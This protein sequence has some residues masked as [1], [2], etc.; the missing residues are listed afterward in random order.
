MITHELMSDKGVLVVCPTG[1]LE[2]CDFQE[3]AKTVDPF[4]AV[5]GGLRGLMIC[6]RSFP[7]WKSF[8]AL[9]RHFQFVKDDHRHIEKVA[10]VTDS[11]F[12]SIMPRVAGHFVKAEVRHFA[13][14]EKENALHWL[15][16]NEEQQ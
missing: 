8:A 3:L 14:S 5:Q 4:I 15:Y 12:L 7:G 16:A 6:T 13:F 1:P 9:L 10:A 11:G 2:V